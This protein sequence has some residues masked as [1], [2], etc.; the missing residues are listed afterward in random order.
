MKVSDL[1]TLQ[2]RGDSGWTFGRV[3]DVRV[4]HQPDGSTTVSAL[5]VG[6]AGLRKR[7]TGRTASDSVRIRE[8]GFAIPWEQVTS[9]DE[10]TITIKEAP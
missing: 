3:H 10:T 2:V 7:L 1:L 4:D 9:L 5:L 6:S 8:H